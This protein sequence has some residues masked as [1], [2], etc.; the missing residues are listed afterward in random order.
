MKS[1]TRV[2]LVLL[3]FTL[4]APAAQLTG[5][6]VFSCDADGN[7]AGDFVWDTRGSDS[8]FYKIWLTSG[9]PDG[10]PNGL[11]SAFIN[12]PSWALAPINVDLPEGR[13]DFTM[14]FQY[15][16]PWHTFALHLFFDNNKVPGIS[17]K[18]PL[19]SGESIPDFS[20]NDAPNTFSFT[21]YPW[22]NAPAAGT[23]SVDLDKK[24]TLSAYYVAEPALFSLDRVSTHNTGAN[25]RQDFV[26]TFSLSVGRGHPRRQLS[27]YCTE[28][29]VCWESVLDQR[30]QVEY[31]SPGGAWTATGDAVVGTGATMCI[32]D[33]VP[34][35]ESQRLYR[36]VEIP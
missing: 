17:V 25:E 22:P 32:V 30:Y 33:K 28:F 4:H 13:H 34:V 7:P 23:A 6:M 20:A 29:T 31:H 8:D 26:G 24:V 10:S 9:V 14:F 5:I 3:L 36:L 16:G 18:A 35:G 12:G 2:Y 27:I 1:L 19:R 15:N 11:T 21:S